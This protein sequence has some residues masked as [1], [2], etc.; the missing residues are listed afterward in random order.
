MK[1][2]APGGE[3]Y[4]EQAN[5]T[6]P[7][8][9]VKSQ[10]LPS[11]SSILNDPAP[12][13]L[14]GL[15]VVRNT[16]P[17]DPFFHHTTHQQH[18]DLYSFFPQQHAYSDVSSNY[19]QQIIPTNP[20]IH[21][22]QETVIDVVVPDPSHDGSYSEPNYEPSDKL[23]A[24]V[25][26]YQIGLCKKESN[27]WRY[28]DL[29]RSLFESLSEEQSEFIDSHAEH[30]LLKTRIQHKMSLTDFV[31]RIML[32]V[33]HFILRDGR[34]PK[35]WRKKTVKKDLIEQTLLESDEE[36]YQQICR[37]SAVIIRSYIVSGMSIN[38]AVKRYNEECAKNE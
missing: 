36:L 38:D 20:S 33:F 14:P 24:N 9:R 35:F 4:E 17:Q 18:T 32:L 22:K 25:L 19:F 27:N 5:I 10:Q 15:D 8:K 29:K 1:R 7:F 13:F 26:A 28:R 6:L 2:V 21:T 34:E 23:P 3:E 37:K 31:T 30:A 16:V 12:T 11:I